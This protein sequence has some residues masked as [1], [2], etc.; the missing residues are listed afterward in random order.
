MTVSSSPF[1]HRTLAWSAVALCAVSAFLGIVTPGWWVALPAVA[2]ALAIL[3]AERTTAAQLAA[4][5][6]CSTVL[7][8]AAVGE[9]AVRVVN[10]GAAGTAGKLALHINRQ[11]DLT[12]AFVKE[13]NAAMR[14]AKERK[15]F[16]QIVSTGLRGE[17]LGYAATINES[18][19]LMGH[20]DD[21]FREFA[22]KRV[23]AV[24]DA[25]SQ[26]ATAL[27][28]GSAAMSGQA[29][30]TTEQACSAAAGAEQASVNVQAVAAA[31]EE[32]SASIAEINR[33][34][35]LAAATAQS[36]AQTAL[37][38][39]QT[40]RGLSEAANRIGAVVQL[41]H[42]IAGQTN[43]L[44]LNATI[45]AARAG[46]AGKGFAVVANEVKNLANQTARATEEITA[47]VAQMQAVSSDAIEAIRQISSTV[48]DIEQA[49]AAV[50]SAIE[51]QSAVTQEIARNVSEAATGTAAVSQAIATVQHVARDTDK[52]AGEVLSSASKLAQMSAQ[53]R[54]EIDG[55]LQRITTA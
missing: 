10:L 30:N 47:Q 44:A 2:A 52:E 36:A 51:Q 26:S 49:S 33:Q 55:F 53:L 21:E 28:T 42:D 35:N 5:G 32:F 45:E 18:L 46:E 38:T 8:R 37:R 50:A 6:H 1:D 29:V 54:T 20:R 25:V 40:V 7:E 23:K 31:V 13:A 9:L 39:D 16:R 22:D 48:A 34:V 12:E 43:L 3:A 24:A 11:L 41:I 15:Y 4:I 27:E 14:S 19:R 17:F